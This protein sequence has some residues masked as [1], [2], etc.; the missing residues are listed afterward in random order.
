LLSAKEI[1]DLLSN[2]DRL[3]N[4]LFF[5]LDDRIG[6]RFVLM[7]A[8]LFYDKSLED[9]SFWDLKKIRAGVVAFFFEEENI[10]SD[11]WLDPNIDW[12]NIIVDFFNE[13]LIIKFGSIKNVIN[14]F[15]KINFIIKKYFIKIRFII[16]NQLK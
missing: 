10:L 1:F 13:L 12:G 7:R 2:G 9:E 16:I 11:G 5:A 6:E 4:E 3:I 8:E 14:L 15:L